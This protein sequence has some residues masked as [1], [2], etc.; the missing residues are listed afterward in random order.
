MITVVAVQDSMPVAVL[1]MMRIG[2]S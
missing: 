1:L 2:H